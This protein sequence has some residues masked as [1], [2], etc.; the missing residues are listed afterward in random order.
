MTGWSRFYGLCR[1]E[2]EFR[3]GLRRIPADVYKEQFYLGVESPEQAVANIYRRL[4]AA[5]QLDRFMPP[6][7]RPP[8]PHQEQQ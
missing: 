8:T 1:R 4:Q 6:P 3:Y 5:G 7:V 2:M